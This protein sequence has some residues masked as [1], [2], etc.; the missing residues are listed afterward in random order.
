VPVERLRDGTHQKTKS[1]P[2]KPKPSAA[3]TPLR[4]KP[5][6]TSENVCD[7]RGVRVERGIDEVDRFID[8]LFR[9]NTFAAFILH[10]HG[11]GA[12]KAAVREHLA[13]SAHVEHFEPAPKEDGGDAL[14]VFWLRG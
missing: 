8:Q 1:Q 9:S 13:S 5:L 6:R 3:T 7:L 11:T 4:E 12:M 2:N 14:T 10:G